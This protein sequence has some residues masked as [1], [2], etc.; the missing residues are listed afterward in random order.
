MLRTR[1]E[2]KPITTARS[3]RAFGHADRVRACVREATC[4][5]VPFA[6]AVVLPVVVLPVREAGVLL[7]RYRR[8]INL[9]VL[10]VDDE[11]LRGAIVYVAVVCM[12]KTGGRVAVAR[13]G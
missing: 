9:L 6:A 5:I 3:R 1:C 7:A 12:R 2:A 10:G 4:A 13:T 11:H 8:V